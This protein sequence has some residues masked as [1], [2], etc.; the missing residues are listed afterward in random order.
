M[1]AVPRVSVTSPRGLFVLKAPSI[2][3]LGEEVSFRQ[4]GFLNLIFL[5]SL[6]LPV[7]FL[8]RIEF[9][10]YFRTTFTHHRIQIRGLDF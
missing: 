10:Q 1:Q 5:M 6:T 3:Q 8:F 7:L 4:I 2:P 9:H